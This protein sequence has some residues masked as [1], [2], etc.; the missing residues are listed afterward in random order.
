MKFQEQL[1]LAIEEKNK[2]ELLKLFQ[3]N[4]PIQYNATYVFKVYGLMHKYNNQKDDEFLNQ[5][6]HFH[7]SS[8]MKDFSL[9]MLKKSINENDEALSNKILELKPN[10]LDI[11]NSFIALFLNS[12]PSGNHLKTIL[13]NIGMQIKKLN[14]AEK[15]DMISYFLET[16]LDSEKEIEK[17]EVIDYFFS[18]GLKPYRNGA[19]FF[20]LALNNDLAMDTWSII[21]D[22][23]YEDKN[24]SF[25]AKQIFDYIKD[26][27]K[28]QNGKNK[29]IGAYIQILEEKEVLNQVLDVKNTTIDKKIKI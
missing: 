8:N 26:T 15:L 2:N 7:E 5:I 13:D 22:N 16:T 29:E 17:K 6:I 1:E 12:I 25:S 4:E 28:M 21:I 9:I 11:N 18:Q 14:F 20:R 3:I 19:S 27:T 10:L 23:L 24:N